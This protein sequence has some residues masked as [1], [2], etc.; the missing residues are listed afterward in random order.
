MFSGG[1]DIGLKLVKVILNSIPELYS[2][3]FQNAVN[4]T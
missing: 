1:M 2:I 4:G 3:G